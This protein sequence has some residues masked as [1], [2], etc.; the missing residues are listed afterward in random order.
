MNT[1]KWEIDQDAIFTET[2]SD[3]DCGD[4]VC[5]LNKH[6]V[7]RYGSL[8]AAAPELLEALENILECGLSPET[9]LKA[10]AVINKAMGE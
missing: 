1:G 5:L 7:K 6:Q 4:L 3:D 10:R 8:I 9:A 2:D